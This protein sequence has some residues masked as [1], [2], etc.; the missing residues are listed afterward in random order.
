[1]LAMSCGT[2][3]L[4]RRAVKTVEMHLANSSGKLGDRSR[5]Q[6]PDALNVAAEPQG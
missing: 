3:A 5:T 2:T 4:A 6:L 1:M